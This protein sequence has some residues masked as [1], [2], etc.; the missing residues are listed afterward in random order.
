MVGIREKKRVPILCKDTRLF[1]VFDH[2]LLHRQRP[3]FWLRMSA[4]TETITAIA[5]IAADIVNASIIITF[6]SH[7]SRKL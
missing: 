7:Y 6:T 2:L 5:I 1:E 4:I 3:C